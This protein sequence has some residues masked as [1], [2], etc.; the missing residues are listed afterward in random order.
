[1]AVGSLIARLGPGVAYLAVAGGYLAAV[2]A[3]GL[4]SNAARAGAAP[5][6]S[7]W[8]SALGFVGVVRQDRRLPTLVALTAAGEVLGFS[9][10]ALLPSLARD[11]LAVGAAG[12]GAMTGARSVGGILGIALVAG[13]GRLRGHGPLFLTVLFLFGGSLVALSA[14]PGFVWVLA[15]LVVVNA[16]GGMSDVLSQGLVQLSVPRELRGRA[17][18][19]W[20]VA[21]GMA[22]LGQLQVGAIASWLGVSMAL[23]ASGFGLM[24]VAAASAML[25]PWLRRH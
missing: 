25:V 7:V 13:L 2:A 16:M 17:G 18:G 24:T 6:G 22:P 20:V 9:H 21:I 8:Q 4:V 5:A 1:L 23:A 10:Q 15:L 14:A 3:L 12:L 11:V 19:A